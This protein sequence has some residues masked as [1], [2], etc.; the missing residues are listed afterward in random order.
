[1]ADSAC[2]GVQSGL[3][4]IKDDTPVQLDNQFAVDVKP[5]ERDVHERRHNFGEK[6]A[7]RVSGFSLQL[8]GAARLEGQAAKAVPFRLELPST[9]FIAN[10]LRRSRLHRSAAE[11]QGKQVRELDSSRP[12]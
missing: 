7:Q 11:P 1:M 10:R 9:R 4:R 2:S 3:Q 8:D 12:S 6:A 5:F